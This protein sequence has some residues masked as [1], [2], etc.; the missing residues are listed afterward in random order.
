M[1]PAIIQRSRL[2][3]SLRLGIFYFLASIVLAWYAFSRHTDFR[4]TLE[5][6]SS[7]AS[8]AQLFYSSGEGYSE[9]DPRKATVRGGSLTWFQP[10]T[11]DLPVKTIRGFRFNPLTKAGTF[12]IRDV[13]VRSGT[14]VL[15]RIPPADIISFN[16]I[17]TRQTQGEQVIFSTVG[18][19][20][21]PG[22][23]FDLHKTLWLRRIRFF[24]RLRRLLFGMVSLLA[25][26]VLMVV[27]KNQAFT[28]KERA[29]INRWRLFAPLKTVHTAFARFAAGISNPDF[30]ILDSYA[31]WFY[32]GCLLLFLA[33][34]GAD[35]N[36]SSAE[37][38]PRDYHHGVNGKTLLGVPKSSR[39][40]EWAYVT[41]DML[42]QAFRADRFAA[43]DT[44]LGGHYVGLTGNLTVLHISSVFR[45]QLWSFFFLPPDYAYAVN[46]QFKALLLVLGVFTWLLLFTRSTFWA[47]TG[48][49]WFFFSPLTQWD[50]S[51]ASALP[52]MIGLIC[53]S[54]FFACYL[55]IGQ[56]R[57]AL[58]AASLGFATCAIDFALCA[59]LPHLV[60][61]AWVGIFSFVSWFCAKRSVILRS[62]AAG[63]RIFAVCLALGIIVAIGAITYRD[64]HQAITVAADTVYPGR[65]IEK[66][67][68]TPVFLLLSHFMQ[69]TETE[70]NFPAVLGNLCESSGYLWLA[71][72]ALVCGWRLNLS[73]VQKFALVSLLVCFCLF[74]AWIFLPVPALV[75]AL[76]GLNRCGTSR[77]MPALGL[78]NIGIV[79]LCGAGLQAR[80]S[81]FRSRVLQ[82]LTP[83]LCFALCFFAFRYA[84]LKLGSYFKIK[85]LVL[86]ALFVTLLVFLY[87]EKRVWA[88]AIALL[89]PQAI[90]FGA[91]NPVQ[92]GL[93]M[94][95]NSDLKRFVGARPE[96][97]NGRW[98]VFSDSVVTSGFVAATGCDVYTG[99][100]HIP[101]IDHFPL[102]AA[103]HVDLE[104][105]N[106]D[107]YLNAHLRAPGEQMFVKLRTIGVVEWDVS[108]ADP[109]LKQIGIRYVA[110]DNQPAAVWSSYMRPLSASPVD[111]FWLYELR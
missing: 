97:L 108:P 21:N 62:R 49:L 103:N 11:F 3:Y 99:L 39:S 71:P 56:N 8:T 76:L 85:E 33:C 66:A 75:G 12:V 93:P 58:V 105:L 48:S 51:W 43:E 77:M 110:F 30:L 95:L 42:N 26:C 60:P 92:R 18:R 80:S 4:L 57:L 88:F 67:G 89:V 31:V 35:L 13:A 94:Y 41:P 78:L 47:V 109:I 19:A 15:L 34:A 27:Y 98:M 23:I 14:N 50:Y 55:T 81:V 87:L 104:I 111:G 82:W 5:I 54:T 29:V 53:L 36:G 91:V 102:F 52:E 107:G 38:L 20:D 100:H 84:D 68:G 83:I 40:D 101:D 22:V 64:L 59:Y 24:Q 9:H 25:C 90:A 28:W 61:L 46:W 73:R 74:L 45:P 44:E 2:S 96:L 37:I 63:F 86:F 65:R 1:K 10:L 79:V 17:A 106:R 6:S 7:T 16:Q 69:W 70:Q 72:I 32:I